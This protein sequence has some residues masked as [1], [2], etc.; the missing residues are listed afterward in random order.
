MLLKR[1]ERA[2][3]ALEK[4][5]VTELERR[6]RGWLLRTPRGTIEADFCVIANGARNALRD[7]GTQWSAGDTM[8]AL[9]Y[10]IPAAQNQPISSEAPVT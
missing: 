1:A 10:Y 2:G 5:R 6:D 3:A 4:V 8:T 7:V 9:G